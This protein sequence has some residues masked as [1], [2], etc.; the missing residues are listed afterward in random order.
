[1]NVTKGSALGA[2]VEP[3]VPNLVAWRS[4]PE[5]PPV[6]WFRREGCRKLHGPWRPGFSPLANLRMRQ[7][8]NNPPNAH[9][10]I[11]KESAL[12]PRCYNGLQTTTFVDIEL[13]SPEVRKTL[14]FNALN[15]AAVQQR[16]APR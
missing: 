11:G 10:Q 12:A 1:M 15:Q 13:G 8:P 5:C 14:R 2:S 16:G 3:A 7:W 9:Y 6:E 4:L